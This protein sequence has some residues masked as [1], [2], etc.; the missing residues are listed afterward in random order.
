MIKNVIFAI[1]QFI[2]FIVV[3]AAGSFFPPFHIEHVLS[4]TPDGTRI[5]IW[6]GALVM[7]ALFAMIVLVEALRKRLDTSGRWTI[8]AFVLAAFVGGLA[9]FGFLTR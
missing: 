5:F 1:L 6:D 7:T 4:V 2:L 3:F 8:L 9:K